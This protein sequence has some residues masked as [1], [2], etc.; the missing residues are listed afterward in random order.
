MMVFT[1]TMSDLRNWT[2][3]V[4]RVK[5]IFGIE[6]FTDDKYRHAVEKNIL[7]NSAFCVKENDNINGQILGGML[8]SGSQQPIYKI[9]WFAV[10]E[11]YMHQGIG[12]AIF[13]HI[14]TK[15]E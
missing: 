8:F 11:S 9:G 3:F 6:L 4:K 14:E 1:A 13:K 2:E 15:I 7:R 10:I 12:T 5:P